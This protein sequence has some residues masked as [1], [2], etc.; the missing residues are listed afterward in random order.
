MTSSSYFYQVINDIYRCENSYTMVSCFYL[1]PGVQNNIYTDA[2]SCAAAFKPCPPP[3]HPH[4]HPLTG[5]EHDD[6]GYIPASEV[7]EEYLT[8]GGACG[9]GRDYRDPLPGIPV[10]V[11]REEEGDLE[12][13]KRLLQQQ[14]SEE[15]YMK[16]RN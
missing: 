11:Q 14:C 5:M 16:P 10:G 3:T 8:M 13:Q 4:K 15:H 1:S 6:G 2:A 9:G 7:P 12:E